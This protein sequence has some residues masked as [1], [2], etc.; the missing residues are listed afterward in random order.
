MSTHAEENGTPARVQ[1]GSGGGGGGGL[2][3]RL[4]AC[5]SS[6]PEQG[7]EQHV[8]PAP[9]EGQPLERDAPQAGQPLQS[10]FQ[11]ASGSIHS[12]PSDQGRVRAHSILLLDGCMHDACR[13]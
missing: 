1:Q 7:Q 11:R 3:R 5:G 12:S 6:Q 9:P 8:K 13:R 10:P 2:F 4:C